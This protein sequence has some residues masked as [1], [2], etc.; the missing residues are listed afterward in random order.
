LVGLV[1]AA[2]EQDLP[3]VDFGWRQIA[4]TG[5]VVASVIGLIPVV[6]DAAGGRWHMPNAGYGDSLSY[7]KSSTLP[8]NRVLWLGDPR[9]IPGGSWPIS[10][11]LAWATSEGGLPGAAN[12][13][14]PASPTA[15]VAVT[16]A[17]A[18][19]R[20][21][22]TVRLGQLLAPT[23]ISTIVVATSTAPIVPGFQ[24]GEPLAP[25]ADLV[26]AL[27]RQSD[28]IEIP[29][30]A[31]EVVFALRTPMATL[32]ARSHGLDP[33]ATP[34][35]P[36]AVAGWSP[37]SSSS[38]TS[39]TVPVGRTTLFTGFAPSG[40][41]S[42]SSAQRTSSA[43]GWASTSSVAPGPVSVSLTSLP[44]NAVINIA[45]VVA[46]IAVMLCLLGRHRWL[47]WWW[48][49]SRRSRTISESED[50]LTPSTEVVS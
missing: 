14:A 27:E 22:R 31:G 29:G 10:P 39:G 28:L 21:G 24:A 9:A 19:A 41:F 1:L 34:S 7:L 16:D 25:P 32:S 13:F 8:A 18:L 2:F 36:L 42:V 43:F 38:A 48:P 23:G 17:L 12:L 15:G 35:D 4:A 50:D 45:M 37:V 6:A 47:D 20:Q 49:A 40:D 30:G 46:W 3:E 5:A 44:T 33:S 11:G 26:P